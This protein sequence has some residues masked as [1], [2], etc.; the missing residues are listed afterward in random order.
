MLLL[1]GVWEAVAVGVEVGCGRCARGS[2]GSGRGCR[3]RTG[4]GCGLEYAWRSLWE[5][6]YECE[7]V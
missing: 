1:V 4:S 6:V 5:L 2:T 3:G 7:S